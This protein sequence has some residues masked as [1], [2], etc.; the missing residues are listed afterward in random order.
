MITKK[1]H[2]EIFDW[3]YQ[4]SR[5]Q[6]RIDNVVNPYFATRFRRDAKFKEGFFFQGTEEYLA[7]TFWTGSDYMNKTP[8]IYFEINAKHGIRAMMVGRDSKLKGDFFEGLSNKMTGWVPGKHSGTFIREFS[9]TT[10]NYIYILS[11]FIKQDKEYIDAEIKSSI[12]KLDEEDEFLLEDEYSSKFG[13]ISPEQ[14]DKLITRVAEQRKREEREKNIES[15]L[16]ESSD[17]KELDLAL[18]SISITNYHDI[19]DIKIDDLPATANWIFLTGMNGFGKTSV[20]QAITLGL[21]NYKGNTIHLDDKASIQIGFLEKG[22]NE[23]NSSKNY[24]E[25][26][27]KSLNKSVAAYGPSRLLISSKDS[28]NQSSSKDSN[29]NSLF[30][31]TS[32]KNIDYELGRASTDDPKYFR[33]LKELIIKSTDG[34]IS[35]IKVKK[36]LI[37]L[38]KEKLNSKEVTGFLPRVHLSAGYRSIIHLVGDILI[39]LFNKEIHNRFEDIS[40]IVLIDEIEN[41]LHPKLQKKIPELLSSVFPKIQ[42]IASTHSPI[43]ILGAPKNTIILKVIRDG[44]GT[45]LRRMDDKLYIQDLLPNTLLSSPIFDLDDITHSDADINTHIRTEKTFVEKQFN[46]KLKDRV[47]DFLTDK[48]EEEIIKLFNSRRK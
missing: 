33:N 43:P 12:E 35:E 2:S 36:G 45:S 24:Y 41:H 39:R 27:F 21:T 19:T 5:D 48:K 38:Y 18:E 16:K 7:I 28:A 37:V 26:D 34:F 46:D 14:F 9:N 42:F 25:K 3:L 11:E 30:E 29:I 4:W 44:S 8:N 22:K 6:Q 13:F 10:Q 1:I 20:L 23:V 47:K 31:P 40:G 15:I 17:L 32:L